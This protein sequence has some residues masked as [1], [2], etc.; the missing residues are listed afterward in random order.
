M[1]YTIKKFVII[2]VFLEMYEFLYENMLV[3]NMADDLYEFQSPYLHVFSGK[4]SIVFPLQF[5]TLF[6]IKWAFGFHVFL[7]YLLVFRT[8]LRTNFLRQRFVTFLLG[9]D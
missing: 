3:Y 2:C 4:I 5:I 8:T 1:S 6:I 9:F 7:H